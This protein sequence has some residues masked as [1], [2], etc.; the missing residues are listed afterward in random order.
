MTSRCSTTSAADGSYQVP[1]SRSGQVR[2]F[3]PDFAPHV[4]PIDAPAGQVRLEPGTVVSGLVTDAAGRP[5]AGAELWLD[6]AQPGGRTDAQGRFH[7]AHAHAE[8]SQVTARTPRLVGVAARRSG[9]LAIRLGAPRTL[10]GTVQE[11]PGRAP[12]AGIT[13]VAFAGTP[14]GRAVTDAQGRYRI[15]GLAPGT[16]QAAAT[17]SGFAP[18]SDQTEDGVD[19]TR[20]ESGRRDLLLVRLP[21]LHGRVEDEQRRPVVGAAVGLAFK[22]PQMYAVNGLDLDTD[23]GAQA[24]VRT[25]ADGG[26]TLPLPLT[27]Q[28][29]AVKALGYERSVVVLKQ[30]F[31]VG[32][33]SLPGGRRARRPPGR[34]A[35]ARGRAAGARRRGR[36]DA[37]RR[38]RAS[39]SP[40]AAPSHPPW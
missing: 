15:E 7:I 22:G 5:A 38:T 33:A 31:A 6:D 26:F 4:V 24:T 28:E 14:A 39:S 10:S 19:L 12:L 21:S 35:P 17:G 36:R 40:R 29:Q 3:H 27:R 20:A 9:P 13:V 2:V 16:Y 34:R 25:G 30:G 11:A 32:T 8:W 23:Q 18:D 1:A 37:G